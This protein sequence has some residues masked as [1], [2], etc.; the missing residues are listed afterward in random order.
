M[1]SPRMGNINED[2][3]KYFAKISARKLDYFEQG[4]LFYASGTPFVVKV[5]RF[6]KTGWKRRKQ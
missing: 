3:I 2:A 6:N 1:K 5:Y 4:D